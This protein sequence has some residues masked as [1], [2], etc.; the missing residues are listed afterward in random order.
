MERRVRRGPADQSSLSRRA[1]LAILH[2]PR[3]FSLCKFSFQEYFIS[4]LFSQRRP[5]RRGLAAPRLSGFWNNG[6][7]AL[8][9]RDGRRASGV[10]GRRISEGREG[11]PAQ[12]PS[13]DEAGAEKLLQF[14]VGGCAKACVR[15]AFHRGEHVFQ[16]LTQHGVG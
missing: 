5:S 12:R 2:R 13:G 1:G 10:A 15:D 4:C 3:A 14:G 9:L 11:G 6:I 8:P 16:R 7:D